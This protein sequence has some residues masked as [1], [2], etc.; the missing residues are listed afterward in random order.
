MF[1]HI[2][3]EGRFYISQE[4]EEGF[5]KALLAFKYQTVFCPKEKKLVR[6]H[7]PQTDEEH[8]QLAEFEDLSFL[9]SSIEQDQ[10]LAIANCEICPNTLKPFE[11]LK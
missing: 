10:A 4:Y 9:G 5:K 7:T 2:R 8:R 1:K 3:R 11:I 6:L